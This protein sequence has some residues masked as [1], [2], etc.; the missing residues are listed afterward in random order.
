M[1]RQAERLAGTHFAVL[2]DAELADLA[3]LTRQ[4]TLAVPARRSRRRRRRP[5]GQRTD[6]RSTSARRAAPA[7][8]RLAVKNARPSPAVPEMAKETAQDLFVP[9]RDA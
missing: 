7:G 1:T 9:A 8:T 3:V 4:L 6:M 5:G 2:S